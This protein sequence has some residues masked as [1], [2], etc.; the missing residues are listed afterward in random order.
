MDSI[1][2]TLHCKTC[3]SDKIAP[4]DKPTEDSVIFCGACGVE[5]GR[6]SDIQATARNAAQEKITKDINDQL[7]DAFKGF[8]RANVK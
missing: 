4:P 2:V 5:L 7:Q 6:W 3:G 1:T 8:P